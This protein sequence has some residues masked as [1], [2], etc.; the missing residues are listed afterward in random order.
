MNVVLL[1]NFEFI[2]FYLGRVLTDIELDIREG[3]E[4]R[5]IINRGD[6]YWDGG[7]PLS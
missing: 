2:E 7:G 4:V 5:C 1:R 6:M 3:V